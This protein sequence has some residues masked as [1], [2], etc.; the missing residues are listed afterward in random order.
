MSR[1][2]R[3]VPILAASF[4]KSD[5][6][7]GQ[8]GIGVIIRLALHGVFSE[9]SFEKNKRGVHGRPLSQGGEKT[10]E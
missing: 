4:L 7:F 5:S 2:G 3:D 6:S 10:S 9:F 8:P 1:S